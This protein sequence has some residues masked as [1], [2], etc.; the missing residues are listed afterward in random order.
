MK[1]QSNKRN[2]KQFMNR[3]TF[4]NGVEFKELEHREKQMGLIT[5]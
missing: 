3:F 1:C 4:Q 5:K 2:D